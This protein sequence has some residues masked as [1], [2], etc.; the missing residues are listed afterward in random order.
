MSPANDACS[1]ETSSVDA[2]VSVG[3]SVTVDWTPACPVA[4]FL[5]EQADSGEDMWGLFM[6]DDSIISPP[7]ANKIRP[8]ITYGQTPLGIG[9][10]EA[11]DP[12]ILVPGQ[13]YRLVLWKVLPTGSTATCLTKFDELC[14]I[15]NTVFTR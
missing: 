7:A 6:P 4:A 12:V 1:A 9:G 8:P 11:D 5:I 15:S 14:L 13:S 10:L 2:K 3:T